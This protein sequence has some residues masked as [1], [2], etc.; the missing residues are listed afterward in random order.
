MREESR[1]DSA[2]K[3]LY[4]PLSARTVNKTV[5]SLLSLVINRARE[6]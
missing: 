6:N 5:T 1:E 3:Q 4:R 2:G